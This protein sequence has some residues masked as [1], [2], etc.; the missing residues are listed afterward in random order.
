MTIDLI[1]TNKILNFQ[2]QQDIFTNINY[3]EDDTNNEEY[4]PK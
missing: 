1:V 3:D 4:M 2:E